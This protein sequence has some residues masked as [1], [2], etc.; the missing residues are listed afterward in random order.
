[1]PPASALFAP[2]VSAPAG[3]TL[4]APGVQ[5]PDAALFSSKVADVLQIAADTEIHG[6]RSDYRQIAFFTAVQVQADSPQAK[7]AEAESPKTKS[8]L[9]DINLQPTAPADPQPAAS[10]EAADVAL[11]ET[12]ADDGSD[13]PT[14][15]EAPLR[16]N[17]PVVSVAPVFMPAPPPIIAPVS[18]EAPAAKGAAAPSPAPAIHAANES[19][20]TP[21]VPAADGSGKVPATEKPAISI[22]PHVAPP[23]DLLAATMDAPVGAVPQPEAASPSP[24]AEVGSE[25]TTAVHAEAAPLKTDDALLKAE[26]SVEAAPP[27]TAPAPSAQTSTAAVQPAPPAP[28]ADIAEHP[29]VQS[30]SPEATAKDAPTATVAIAPK[31]TPDA[32][33]AQ[34]AASGVQRLAETVAAVAKVDPAKIEVKVSRPQPIKASIDLASPAPLVVPATDDRDA[35][36]T[37]VG[38]QPP[39]TDAPSG[40]PLFTSP[41]KPAPHND[42]P[43][44]RNAAIRDGEKSED[45]P[46]DGSKALTAEAPPSAAKVNAPVTPQ[47]ETAAPA[48]DAPPAVSPTTSP[49]VAHPVEAQQ[50]Q[51]HAVVDRNLGLSTLSHATIETTAQIAAQIARKLDGRSTRFDMVLTP[52]DLGRVDVS[53]EIDT[54][55]QLA[56]RLAFDNPAAAADLRGRA[57]ELRR[58]L[59]DAGF[60]VSSDALDFSHRDPS[61]GGGAFERQQQRNALFSGGSRLA[62]QAD[63]LPIPAPGAWTNL[64]QTPDRVDVRV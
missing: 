23:A 29:A 20:E 32:A 34:D 11:E 5:G 17:P 8:P 38:T 39:A 56:A 25:A 61:A 9:A 51:Q 43:P 24:S 55:G 35:A 41:L 36:P 16:E 13:L 52:E 21:A 4:A 48:P 62:L 40:A 1:M 59:Q 10:A 28:P 58:Q 31:S 7:N 30:A 57:D 15:A 50:I 14:S 2:I 33:P 45:R 64:S 53:L 44:L 60:Q 6:R 18:Q 49:A 12:V 22:A 54:D 27:K 46:S 26:A 3:T 63:A 19:G 37:P 42:Q 47:P